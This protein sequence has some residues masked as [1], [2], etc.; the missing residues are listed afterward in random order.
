MGLW[1]AQVSAEQ[2][3]FT[4]LGELGY[5]F[6]SN[7]FES[8]ADTK[9]HTGLLRLNAAGFLYQ[10]VDPYAPRPAGWRRRHC[11]VR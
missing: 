8:A 7:Q 1:T 10:P 6:L 4:W 11:V 3:Q 9:E 5:D 2:K